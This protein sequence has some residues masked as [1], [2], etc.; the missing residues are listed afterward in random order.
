[1]VKVTKIE[2]GFQVVYD[3]Q[4]YALE[5]AGIVV[6]AP[7]RVK[8]ANITF[9]TEEEW[10][11]QIEKERHKVELQ[12][13]KQAGLTLKHKQ[14]IIIS[15]TDQVTDFLKVD[16]KRYKVLEKKQLGPEKYILK[17]ESLDVSIVSGDKKPC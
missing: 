5:S 1:M 11:Q 15:R 6:I 2:N 16:G 9:W 10:K 4:P 3:K 17:L 12:V 7:S 14:R 13:A 8:S